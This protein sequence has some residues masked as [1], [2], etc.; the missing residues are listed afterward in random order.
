MYYLSKL[1]HVAYQLQSIAVAVGVVVV[2]D[3]FY[4]ALFSALEQTHCALAAYNSQR[5][6][7]FKTFFYSAFLTISFDVVYLQRCLLVTWLVPRETA[8]VAE[9]SVYTMQPC[10]TSRHFTQNPHA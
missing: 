9:R 3:H 2:V 6:T 1:Q 5:V 7:R 10:T 4:K 8:T